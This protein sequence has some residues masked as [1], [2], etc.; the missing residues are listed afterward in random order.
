[1]QN[2]DSFFESTGYGCISHPNITLSHYPKKSPKITAFRKPDSLF[3]FLAHR[4]CHRITARIFGKGLQPYDLS[5]KICRTDRLEQDLPLKCFLCSAGL[6]L[7][8][9]QLSAPHCTSSQENETAHSTSHRKSKTYKKFPITNI[10][11]VHAKASI[12]LIQHIF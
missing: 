1:M 9:P 11:K 8:P 2:S 7:L 3:K 5:R 12:Q 4:Y 10:N 6:F